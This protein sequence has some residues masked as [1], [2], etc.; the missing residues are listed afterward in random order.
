VLCSLC[1]PIDLQ[2]VQADVHFVNTRSQLIVGGA[3]L[4]TLGTF[5]L[6]VFNLQALNCDSIRLP[7]S[8]NVHV[9][10][11]KMWKYRFLRNATLHSSL[12]CSWRSQVRHVWHRWFG[13][14]SDVCLEATR[15]TIPARPASTCRSDSPIGLWQRLHSFSRSCLLHSCS[16]R[17]T[18]KWSGQGRLLAFALVGVRLSQLL[19]SD[20]DHDWQRLRQTMQ[21][22]NE[23]NFQ[24]ETLKRRL[25]HV[26]MSDVNIGR[27]VDKGCNAAVYEATV[28]SKLSFAVKLLFN[29]DIESNAFSIF[30]QMSKECVP[31][32]GS[33]GKNLHF[34]RHNTTKQVS[35]LHPNIVHIYSVLVDR[36]PA[37]PDRGRHFETALPTRFNPN[38]L[39]RDLTMFLLMKQYKTN[40]NNYLASKSIEPKESLVLFA[41]LLSGLT[42]LHDQQIA[43]RDLKANN[44]LVDVQSI[45]RSTT[46]V[47]GDFGC[48]C[49]PLTIAYPNDQV[50]KGGNRSLMAP[51][52]VNTQPGRFSCL[53]YAK[54]DLW[55]AGTIAF[56]LFGQ[57]NPF[58]SYG[59]SEGLDS[60]TYA[61]NQVPGCEPM[62]RLA[63]KL[64]RQI[65]QPNPDDRPSARLAFTVS[66]LSVLYDSWYLQVLHK[67]TSHLKPLECMAFLRKTILTQLIESNNE[68]DLTLS[69]LRVQLLSELD[70]NDWIRG[71]K[72]FS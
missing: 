23:R 13:R 68:Q 7:I 35:R 45:D 34:V 19:P 18:G 47:I 72:H 10:R 56:E 62:P 71:L 5:K 14:S 38:G 24:H 37:L 60:A 21:K 48:S 40:L 51:E 9:P 1:D 17:W 25:Q 30:R 15:L 50:C 57:Q 49:T 28:D 59:T 29:F 53:N 3:F 31:F 36:F 67:F 4:F 33:F 43:H 32:V 64:V 39:A 22:M 61:L 58:Y 69:R 63:H 27:Y 6:C 12:V 26:T 44:L 54:S 20:E 41:Q 55:A 52:I 2:N 66:V 16:S 65:L 70:V 42:F 46:L 11:S 8:C